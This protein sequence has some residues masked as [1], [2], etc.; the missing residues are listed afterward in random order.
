MI[1]RVIEAIIVGF[2]LASLII[3]VIHHG[4]NY[5]VTTYRGAGNEEDE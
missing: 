5:I 1:L 3:V 2:G 4:I